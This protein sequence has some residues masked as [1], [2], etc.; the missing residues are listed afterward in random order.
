MVHFRASVIHMIKL[1]RIIHDPTRE[2]SAIPLTSFFLGV[3]SGSTLV[4]FDTN[5]D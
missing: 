4:T 1:S 3:G 5:L 2:A